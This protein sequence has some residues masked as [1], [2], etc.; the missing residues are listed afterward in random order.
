MQGK[1]RSG[2]LEE[3]LYMRPDESS[4]PNDSKVATGASSSEQSFPR[5]MLTEQALK[6]TI[7]PGK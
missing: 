1:S 6:K 5:V 3:H 2:F 4:R 7:L